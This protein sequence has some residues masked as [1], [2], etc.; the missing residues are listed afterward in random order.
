MRRIFIDCGYLRGKGTLFFKQT[1]DYS[2]DFEF[3][4]FDPSNVPDPPP[5]INFNN[6][7]A[8]I[9]DGTIDF[10]VR[11]GT[12]RSSVIATKNRHNIKKIPCIDFSKW[13]IDNFDKNDFMVLKMDIEGAEYAVLKKMYEDKSLHYFDIAYVEPHYAKD[14]NHPFFDFREKVQSEIKTLSFRTAI[15][16]YVKNKIS[17]R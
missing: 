17:Q 16:W 3:Y 11:G 6:Q 9:Y 13:V 5:E 14:V 8:W 4:A 12:K 2:E 10:Y 7:A 1:K 15:E